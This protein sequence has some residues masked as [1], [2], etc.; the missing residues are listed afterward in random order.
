MTAGYQQQQ[1]MQK[2]GG[3]SSGAGRGNA[4][5][6]GNVA[7]VH[8]SIGTKA[9]IRSPVNAQPPTTGT[10]ATHSTAPS[11]A[12]TNPNPTPT[13]TSSSSSR[14]PQSATKGRN[15]VVN[16]AVPSVVNDQPSHSRGQQQH[17]SG[18]GYLAFLSLPN[19]TALKPA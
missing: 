16:A 13:T 15:V 12:Q 6:G 2:A 11:T 19:L 14:R 10:N 4:N 1:V 3:S 9:V 8:K 18:D 7:T 17:T 5:G